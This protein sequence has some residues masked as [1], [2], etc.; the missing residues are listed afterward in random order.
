MDSNKRMALNTLILYTKLVIT[1]VVN[2]YS[3]R[4]IL[5]AMGIEDYGIV[6]LISGIVAMLSFV[7][8]SMSVSSQ[9]YISVTMGKNDFSQ[10]VKVFNS[11]FFLHLILGLVLFALLEAL[12]PVIFHSSIQIPEA[13]VVSA[14]VLYHLTILGTFLVII[15]VPFDATLNAHENMLWFSIASIIE[16]LIRLSGAV[17]LLNYSHDKLIFYGLL[18]VV[19][20]LVSMIIKQVYCRNKYKESRIALKKSEKGLMKDMFSFSFWNMFSALSL[21][22]RSQG[23]AIVMNTFLGVVINASYGIANQLSGQLSTFT[24]TINKAMNP[25]IMQNAGTGN[26]KQVI[27]LSIKQCKYSSMLLSFAIVPLYIGTPYILNIWLKDTPEYCIEFTRCILVVS[28]IQQLTIGIMSCIQATGKIRSYSICVSIIILFNIP[29]IYILL[30][31]GVNIT[32]AVFSML[33]I[34]LI[35]GVVRL[36]FA[37]SLIELSIITFVKEVIVPIFLIYAIG[38]LGTYIFMD[39]YVNEIKSITDF[40]LL[41]VVTTLIIFFTIIL[42]LHKSERQFITSIIKKRI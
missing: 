22:G 10:V 37:K 35:A 9:R 26:I 39:A 34:E 27:S 38:C 24:A 17:I 42:C 8:N 25:Q 21:T 29:I 4:L 13:R 14:Q 3:T 23:V 18:V 7:Q 2:L 15:T 1:I 36:L 41:F 6:N 32:I 40:S 33:L 5:N 11:S 31:F 20:R 19:I 16:S 12:L 30:H 28:V